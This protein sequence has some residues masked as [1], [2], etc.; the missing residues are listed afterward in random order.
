M[1][2][3]RCAVTLWLLVLLSACTTTVLQSVPDE[4]GGEGYRV[5]MRL[6]LLQDRLI[7]RPQAYLTNAPDDLVS[8]SHNY[9]LPSISVEQFLRDPDAY[10]KIYGVA[11]AGTTIEVTR[12]ARHTH[13]VLETDF[14]VTARITSGPFAGRRVSLDWIS[15]HGADGRSPLVDPAELAPAR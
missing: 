2:P 14:E 9:M 5:G 1:G 3:V 13:P 8:W 11:T 10:P 4:P 15:K 7:E 12:I 6:E